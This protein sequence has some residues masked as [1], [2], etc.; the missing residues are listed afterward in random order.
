[1]S[2]DT[3]RLTARQCAEMWKH[4]EPHMQKIAEASDGRMTLESILKGLIE[5]DNQCWVV[6]RDNNPVGFCLTEI[7]I[8]PSGRKSL[9]T[10]G[11]SGEDPATW[12]DQIEAVEAYG[13][14][15]G[16]DRVEIV[17]RPG[18]ERLLRHRGYRRWHSVLEL[19]IGE[20]TTRSD[21]H[22]EVG[23]L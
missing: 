5:A 12:I 4:L 21:S 20:Q 19:T 1:V 11:A 13:R 23:T 22:P 3:I 9:N 2:F 6:L 8:Y 7:I 17:G 18:W 14:E 16:A 15:I 10:C